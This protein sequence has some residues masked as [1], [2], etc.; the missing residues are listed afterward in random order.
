MTWTA[1]TG[2]GAP[3][4][5]REG[6]SASN[7]NSSMNASPSPVIDRFEVVAAYGTGIAATSY[8]PAGEPDA[9]VLVVPAM[10][11]SQSYYAEFAGWLAAR[12]C[13]A[14]TFDYRG[15]GRSLHGPLRRAEADLV[16]WGRQDCGAMLE[17][18][19]ARSGARPL[20]WIGHSLGGQLLPFV[21]NLGR[22]SKVITVATGSGYWRENAPW[23]R[24]RAFWFWYV[25]VPLA[26]LLFGCFPG[27]SLRMVGDLPRGVMTQWRRWCLHPK[28]AAGAEGDAVRALFAA[29]RLPIVS[30]S[31]TD[32]E[33]MSARNVEAI[34]G[35][36]T[37]APVTF[38]RISPADVGVQ[39]V[40]HFG[41]FRA[42]LAAT[43]WQDL[44]L[45]AL[46]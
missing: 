42:R 25:L 6:S 8:A 4:V 23:L 29:V 3:D 46:R 12:D 22:V 15:T 5:A 45:P 43:L 18:A 21:E 27:R 36:Y 7:P 9:V 16:T 39:R 31:F 37:G 20:L 34:H 32:D 35:Q 33:Y 30:L 10:G 28:Y 17:A 26:L 13:L 44:L 1:P 41:F 38:R 11:V 14:L 40:G 2:A 19:A 24:S